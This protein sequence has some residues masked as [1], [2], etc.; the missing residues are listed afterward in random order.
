MKFHI[1]FSL[2]VVLLFLN[3]PNSFSEELVLNTNSKVY[4]PEHTLQVYGKGLPKENLIIRVFAPDES[5]AKF[6]Q[7][8]TKEDGSFNYALLTWPEPSTNF[9]YGTYTVELISTE[10]NGASQKIDV[11]FSSTTE[12]LDV[13]VER[14]VSTLVF[15]PETAAINQPIR[16]FV[17]TTS[18]GLLIGNEPAELLGTTHVHLP[19]GISVTLTNSF[20]TL[21]QGLYYVDYTPIEEGT[22]VF[23][24]VAF[25]QGTT[26]HGSAATTVLSQDLGG[27][28]NQI[29]KL[30]SILDE[31]SE[32]LDVLKS[33]IEGFDTTLKYA[34]SQIDENIGTFALSA[35]SISESSAQLNALLLPI[36]A[37]VGLIVALQVAILARRR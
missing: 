19:S 26:S 20:K 36:I 35:K 10:Q 34:S 24:V 2:F 15:A 21:H 22:H 4:S 17:Q 33:E 11:K 5:I 31:T 32:E 8:T 25:S 23:H 14:H 37:S 12:L 16:V 13:P 9:P 1:L 27:I 28:S 6:D 29:I 3:I 18:D 30:N 7:I